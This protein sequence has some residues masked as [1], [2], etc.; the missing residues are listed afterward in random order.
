MTQ[1]GRGWQG[2]PLVEEEWVTVKQLHLIFNDRF[3][4]AANE[5][6]MIV[7]DSM[8]F[9]C[10]IKT[11]KPEGK[12][13]Q[14]EVSLSPPSP[15]K[16]KRKAM[17]AKEMPLFCCVT[18]QCLDVFCRWELKQCFHFVGLGNLV[19]GLVPCRVERCPSFFLWL[20]V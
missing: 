17:P 5:R 9:S 18:D 8:C 14:A 13:L 6:S 4:R 20:G 19:K 15:L 7:A 2:Q 11:P 1:C 10:W 16:R 3:Q 12:K